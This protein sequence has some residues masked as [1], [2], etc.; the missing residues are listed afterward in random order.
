M[1]YEVITTELEKGD[2]ENVLYEKID[3]SNNIIPQILRVLY[4]HKLQSVIT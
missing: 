3:F 2:E 4:K 1:L